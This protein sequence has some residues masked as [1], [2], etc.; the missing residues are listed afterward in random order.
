M[1]DLAGLTAATLPA[2]TAAADPAKPLLTWYDD[3]TG[4]WV[5]LSG[6]TFA[7]WVAKTANLLVDGCGLGTGDTA[8]VALPPHWQTAA[9]LV[10]CWSAGV[11]VAGDGTAD[12]AVVF[13][14]VDSIGGA[15]DP[16]VGDDRFALGFAAM[17]M[18]HRGPL[19]DGWLDYIAEVRPHGDHFRPV[20]PPRPS[21]LA[22]GR[23][24]HAQLLERAAERAAE[25]GIP[26]AG[27]VLI[28]VTKFPDPVDHLL[29]PWARG[30][31]V[32][33]SKDTEATALR[34]RAESERAG[35]ILS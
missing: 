35:L 15:V 20:A 2:R 13:A 11:A 21:D 6:N 12:G 32:V 10:G 18:P 16:S 30:A 8:L 24:T 23:Q 26:T 9:I 33:L 4:E 1:T 14:P 34:R 31:S 28:D 7:N 19:P 17:G 27:R 22:L 5:E 3:G 25:F 29:A